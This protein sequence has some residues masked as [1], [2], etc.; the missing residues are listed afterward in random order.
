MTSGRRI[1]ILGGTF[2]PI[3][4]GHIDLATT[5]AAQLA[6]TELLVMPSHIPPHRPQPLASG[7]HRFA[8][9]SMTVAG[10][11]GWCA[12]DLELLVDGPTYT[13]D[14]IRRFHER[15]YSAVEL[16]FIIGADAFAAI[17][18]WRDYPNILERANFAVVSRPGY[19]AGAL[20]SGLP[21]L[22]PRMRHAST[23]SAVGPGGVA[24]IDRTAGSAPVIF[25]IDAPTANVSATAIRQRLAEGAS[26]TGMVDPR[27]Q[28]H[29]EQHGLYTSMARSRRADEHVNLPAVGR[30]HGQS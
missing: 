21:Q 1:G 16:Y 3:H 2:D 7:F 6:L 19:P 26:I 25:L 24:T 10:R 28:Q 14:T 5:A 17:V 29:I 22:A 11:A 12:S 13:T 8:M 18:T 30:L 4:T 15:G 27:V 9:A 20:P 23:D